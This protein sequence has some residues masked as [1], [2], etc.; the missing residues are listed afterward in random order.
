MGT[1]LEGTVAVAGVP[2]KV[3]PAAWQVAQA[4]PDT[5]ACTI[6]GGAVPLTLV[7]LKPPAAKLDFEWQLSQGAAPKGTWL[8]G[9]SSSVGGD[10]FAKLLPAAWQVAQPLAMFTWFIV[11]EL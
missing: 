3:L 5:A 7:N 4:T 1:W 6:A 10:M 9:G 11:P 8:A 2:M